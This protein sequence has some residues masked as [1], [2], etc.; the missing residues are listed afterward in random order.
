MIQ[1]LK[2]IDETNLQKLKKTATKKIRKK[3]ERKKKTKDDE[4]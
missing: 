2:N 1:S 3:L 4:I